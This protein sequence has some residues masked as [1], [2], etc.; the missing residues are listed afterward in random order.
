MQLLVGQSLARDIDNAEPAPLLGVGTVVHVDEQLVAE[1][2]LHLIVGQA[3]EV[4]VVHT[5]RTV[6]VLAE[7]DSSC[8]PVMTL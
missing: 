6:D 3:A 5:E 7:G 2:D 4:L 8:W 1:N